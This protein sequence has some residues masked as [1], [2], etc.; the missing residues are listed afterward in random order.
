MASHD[1]PQDS[2]ELTEANVRSLP[3][4]R[5][6]SGRA[7]SSV[8][9][10]SI[11]IRPTNHAVE[12]QAERDVT[13]REIQSAM[14]HGVWL[15]DPEGHPRRRMVTDTVNGVTVIVQ[16]GVTPV[17]VWRGSFSAAANSA[18]QQTPDSGNSL[19][20]PV[21]P[22][23]YLGTLHREIDDFYWANEYVI[24]KYGDFGGFDDTLDAW[25]SNLGRRVYQE[26]VD[27]TLPGE[28]HPDSHQAPPAEWQ[29]S[30][31]QDMLSSVRPG[32]M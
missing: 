22:P 6:S 25:L 27:W 32:E 3:A 15:P 30:L 8:A 31:L 24:E 11:A 1:A 5:A 19:L 4:R 9:T 18:T 17:T 12:R 20:V 23:N 14:R 13:H 2:G 7:S 16:D 29:S 26:Q 28:E 10:S 21:L